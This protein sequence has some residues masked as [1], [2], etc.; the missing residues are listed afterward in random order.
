MPGLLPTEMATG[1]LAK[2]KT[3][4]YY[5]QLVESSRLMPVA[6]PSFLDTRDLVIDQSAELILERLNRYIH[7]VDRKY[8]QSWDTIT[9][10]GKFEQILLRLVFHVRSYIYY[11]FKITAR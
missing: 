10:I 5:N 7:I 4:L 3:R 9:F 6:S 2:E 8:H 1:S 11:R